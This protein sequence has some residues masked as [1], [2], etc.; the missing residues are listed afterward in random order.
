MNI[1]RD[2]ISADAI[3]DVTLKELLRLWQNT[4]EAERKQRLKQ[5]II[6]IVEMQERSSFLARYLLRDFATWNVVLTEQESNVA[7]AH[8]A[9]F[10]E[11]HL[12]EVLKENAGRLEPIKAINEILLR[13]VHE[14]SL[15]DFAITASKRLRYDTTIRFLADNLKKRGILSIE[16]EAKQVL[17]T[18]K[19]AGQ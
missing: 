9:E 11:P 3:S 7:T 14:L 4:D 2:Y 6:V 1:S 5:A 16:K 13:V 18:C 8:K 17:V 12:I 19:N 15:A 10:F